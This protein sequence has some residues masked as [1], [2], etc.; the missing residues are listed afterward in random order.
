MQEQVVDKLNDVRKEEE[1]KE[2]DRPSNGS[3]KK[4]TY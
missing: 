3:R 1:E 2:I 4:G